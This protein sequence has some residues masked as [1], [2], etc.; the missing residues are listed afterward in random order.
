[1]WVNGTQVA[2]AHGLLDAAPLA[3]KLITEFN[4]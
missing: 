1:V 4:R 3:G 2:D